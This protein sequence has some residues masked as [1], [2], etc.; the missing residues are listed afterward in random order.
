MI[1]ISEELR[2]DWSTLAKLTMIMMAMA[3]YCEMIAGYNSC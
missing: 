1:V 3:S 2:V